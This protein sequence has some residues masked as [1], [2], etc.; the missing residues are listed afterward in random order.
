MN[1][2]LMSGIDD[3]WGSDRKMRQCLAIIGKADEK[4]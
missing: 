1:S 2:C 3:I 4:E